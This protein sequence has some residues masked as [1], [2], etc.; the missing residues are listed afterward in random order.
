MPPNQAPILEGHPPPILPPW[1]QEGAVSKGFCSMLSLLGAAGAGTGYLLM[2]QHTW[3]TRGT[4]T[5]TAKSTEGSKDGNLMSPEVYIEEGFI[6]SRTPKP[7]LAR[8]GA[9]LNLIEKNSSL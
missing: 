9:T 7:S 4:Q 3:K 1:I 2:I 5:H 8:S 6:W